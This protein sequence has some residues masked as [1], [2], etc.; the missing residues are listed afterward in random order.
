VSARLSREER[1]ARQLARQEATNL[2][3]RAQRRAA[4]KPS[5]NYAGWVPYRPTRYAICFTDGGLWQ[6]LSSR[7]QYAPAPPGTCR[8]AE[9]DPVDA[10]VS[11]AVQD[12]PYPRVWH[13]QVECRCGASWRV[14]IKDR[15]NDD[16]MFTVRVVPRQPVVH[17]WAQTD[18]RRR[19]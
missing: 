13:W 7:P 1:V 14:R 12:Q 17:Q 16:L 6:E 3:R 4:G 11:V 2:A 15:Y 18:D 5:R 19:A 8:C 9:D 10:W